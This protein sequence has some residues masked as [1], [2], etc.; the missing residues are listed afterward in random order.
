M[1]SLN[2]ALNQ[3]YD[4]NDI[5]SEGELRLADRK[6]A[7]SLVLEFQSRSERNPLDT[8]QFASEQVITSANGF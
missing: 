5:G 4:S 2:A 8:C 6:L 7:Q 3:K 1:F